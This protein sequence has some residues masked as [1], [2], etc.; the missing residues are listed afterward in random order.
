MSV[1]RSGGYG[2]YGRFSE[3]VV[4]DKM[5]ESEDSKPVLMVESGE[6]ERVRKV[7]AWFVMLESWYYS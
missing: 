1:L 4:G 5:A 7:I 6:S 2:D 3:M